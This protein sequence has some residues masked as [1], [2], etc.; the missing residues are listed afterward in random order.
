[1]KLNQ[2]LAGEL[3][4]R[5]RFAADNAHIEHLL[6]KNHARHLALGGFYEALPALADRFAEA[7]Q[8]C[9]GARLVFEGAF[10]K[11]PEAEKVLAE[12]RGWIEQHRADICEASHLQ[13][14]VD[15]IVELID[16]TSYKLSLG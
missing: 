7:A 10:V 5:C 8:G 9:C 16:S 13:N 3:F 2:K 4:M 6:T 12:L 1:M 14:I 11:K 15:E